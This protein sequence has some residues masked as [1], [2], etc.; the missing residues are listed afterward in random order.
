MKLLRIAFLISLTI[1]CYPC[2][3]QN[4]NQD[5]KA[6]VIAKVKELLN[7]NFISADKA[8]LVSDSLNVTVFSGVTSSAEFVK[9][10]NKKL[11]HYTKDKH[12]S[13]EYNPNYAKE[14][15]NNND[16]KA[17]QAAKEK[18][19]KYGF[20]DLKILPENIG[21]LGLKYFA[22]TSNAKQTALQSLTK[23]KGTKSL[24]LD[25]RGNS[26]GSGSMI[27]LLCSFFL[28]SENHPLL[29]IEYKRGDTVTLKTYPDR[30]RFTYRNPVFILTDQKTFS[31]A[32][33]FTLIMKNRGRAVVIGETTAGAGNIAGPY[34]LNN[35]YIITIPVGRIVD[36]LTQK[37]WEGVGVVPD[38]N[39]NPSNALEVAKRLVAKSKISKGLMGTL[40]IEINA[41][42]EK[43]FEA[44]DSFKVALNNQWSYRYANKAGYDKPIESLRLKIKK[45]ITIDEFGVEIEKILGQG[46][47]GHSRIRGYKWPT[48]FCLP[49]LIEAEGN[50]FIAINSGRKSFLS[51]GFPYITKIDGKP[52]IEWYAKAAARVPKG[53]PQWVRHRSIG[54]FMGRLDYWREEFNL[55]K[56][57]IVTVE[58]TNT[59]GK[60]FRVL[61]L[62]VAETPVSYGVWPD[63]NSGLLGENIGYLR[64]ANMQREPSTAE[65][66]AWMPKFKNVDGLIIDV[67]DNDGGDRDALT[68]LYSYL[69]SPDAKPHVFNAAAYRL[70]PSR[71]E[72]YLAGHAMFK[73]NSEKWNPE[74]KA[75]IKEFKKTFKPQWQLPKGQ[76]SEWHYM[77]LRSKAED[78]AY[79]FNKPVVVLMNAKSFSATDIF[80]AG[81]KGLKNVTLLGAPSGGGSGNKE[82]IKLGTTPI[83]LE[84]STMA[85]FQSNGKLFDGNGVEPDI[86]LQ[87][88]PEYYIGGSD[89]V[90]DRAVIILKNKL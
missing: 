44:L 65:I 42:K 49:F 14:L 79:Y 86:L 20:S 68:L 77:I 5:E 71:N 10:L 47:D 11:F 78:N 64:L 22:D 81:L 15:K 89:N 41:D 38:M 39:T 24:I 23:L 63:R 37:G 55:P 25:L 34:F 58:L 57:K 4:I 36:P 48:G 70:H 13:V 54:R 66:R 83:E 46:I 82:T 1:I 43:L 75:A 45:G 8:Q 53:S 21:Y 72:N 2:L 33:A 30:N 60:E 85:S 19:E 32:E 73:E 80:L 61:D 17:E 62:A 7:E 16:D 87:Q 52:I 27:Q 88:V 40:S 9:L 50:R 56:R 74:E 69:S 3:A 51:N 76:F 26:G 28:A 29:Q 90:L 18:R 31:A 35:D 59:S 84:I 67:R 12:L 6:T